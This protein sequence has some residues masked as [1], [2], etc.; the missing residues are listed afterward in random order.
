MS[1]TALGQVVIVI[2]SFEVVEAFHKKGTLYSNRPVFPMGGLLLGFD[3][4]V[5]LAQYGDRWRAARKLFASAFGSGKAI[6]SLHPI[7]LDE[8]R[9]FAKRLSENPQD[10]YKHCNRYVFVIVPDL[11]SNLSYQ[12]AGERNHPS[13]NIRSSGSRVRR[14]LPQAYLQSQW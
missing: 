8:V 3:Q 5:V 10:I 13:H 6:Q 11:Y 1:I 2:N 7:I 14:S 4:T 9:E 12:Q